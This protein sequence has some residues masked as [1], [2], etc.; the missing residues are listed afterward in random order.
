MWGFDVSGGRKGLTDLSIV[1]VNW[2]TKE[3]LLRCLESV[4]QSA[5]R[6][7]WEVMVIDNGSQDGSAREAKRLFPVIHLIANEKNLGFAKA[8][9]Q[10]LKYSSGEYLLLLNPDTEVRREAIVKLVHFMENNP[11]VGVAGPQLLNG[12]GSRQNSIANFPSLATEL[13]NKS[14]LRWIF[15]NRFPGKE[16]DYPEPIEV[17]SVIGA[18]LLTRREAIER[19]G[20]LDEDYFLFFEETDWC[21]RMKKAGWKVYHVP[22][23]KIVHFQGKGAETRKRE[24]KVEYY[25]SRYHFFKKNR[26]G[27][28][29]FLLL[30]GSMAKL[31]I[32][33]LSLFIGCLLTFFLVK[34]WRK[35]L[36]IYLYLMVWHLRLCPRE[37]GL[38]RMS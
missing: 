17:E 26:G 22:Q 16:R 37:M 32:E 35:Q 20:M 11:D 25:R 4:F 12:D 27:F 14:L 28:Q 24:A 21:Y 15:P 38:N 13:L 33:L 30:I 10:G 8:T 9:N 29:W 31:K 18:C 23:S 2:N 3:Y 5:K 34:E 7:S 1:I 19:I 36:S 6:N